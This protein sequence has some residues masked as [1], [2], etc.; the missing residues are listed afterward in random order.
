LL[1]FAGCLRGDTV[2]R[3]ADKAP[4]EVG[5]ILKD[6]KMDSISQI[7][8]AILGQVLGTKNVFDER[9]IL[10]C[11]LLCVLRVK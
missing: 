6:A 3:F 5:N 1:H 7:D 2:E 8:K 10:C 4:R 11:V 9:G